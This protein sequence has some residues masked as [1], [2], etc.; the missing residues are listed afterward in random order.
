MEAYK[1]CLKKAKD[2]N[3]K[4]CPRGYCTAKSKFEVYP[5]AYANGY[6]SQVCSG[7]KPDF[8]GIERNDYGNAPK[9]PNSDLSRWYDEQWV[10]VCERDDK[11][12]YLPCGR[13]KAKLN[14]KNYPY[15]RPLHKLNGTTVKSVDELTQEQLNKMCKNKR[16]IKPGVDGKPT[17][18]YVS[19][20]LLQNPETGRFVKA[21]GKIGKKLQRGGGKKY[22]PN[23]TLVQ[24]Y[25][26]DKA[27]QR[28]VQYRGSTVTLYSPE[29]SDR[30]LK[31]L[32]VY[33][34]DPDTGEIK[35]V[36]FG[37]T[38]YQDYT[39]HRDKDRRQSY[40]ARSG[41]IKC[42]N[43]ECGVDSANYWSRMVLWDC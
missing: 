1:A 4:L 29:L 7:G 30:S 22:L 16:S 9:D 24:E 17:R 5:S 14:A 41:G 2:K 21:N 25:N 18:V 20:L 11:G 35:K 39:L 26:K 31:K 12:N 32:K 8:E 13:S 43:K 36:D 15:C 23:M 6:A 34:E 19:D 40:C 33:V 27:K 38:D 37:H 3:M 28:K 42:G 10:N